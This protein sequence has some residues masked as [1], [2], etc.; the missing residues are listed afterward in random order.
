MST[1]KAPISWTSRW[2]FIMAATGSAVGLGNIWKFPYIVGDNGGGAFVLLY[3]LCIAIV[4]LPVLIAEILLG[5]NG[6]ANPI[7]AMLKAS[8]QSDVSKMWMG[9]GVMGALAG[10]LILSFYSLVG[11]WIL[12]YIMQ[13]AQSSFV[14]KTSTEVLTIFET[15]RNDTSKQLIWHG[16]F[17]SLA[18]FIVAGGV[19]KGVGVAVDIMMP[20]LAIILVVLLGYAY[21]EGNLAQAAHFLFAFDFSKLNGTAFLEALGHAMFT[22]S[23][24]M[25][26]IMVYG[27]YMPENASITRTSI[28]V[29]LLDTA[30]SIIAAL[31]IFSLV[32]ANG[33]EP[34]QGPK[35]MFVSLPLAFG[36]MSGGV[37]FA[38]LFFV[39]VS[40]AALSSAISLLE[41]AVSWLDNHTP[42]GRI[43]AAVI[44]G[45]ISWAGGIAC[46]YMDDVFDTIDFI[47]SNVLLPLGALFIA[48]FVGW[49]LKRKVAKT[50]LSDLSYLQFN[51]WYAVLR[52]FTPLGILAIFI[53][54]LWDKLPL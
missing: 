5:K 16:A 20:S 43:A 26:A 41:P 22:L 44:I 17:I 9:V 19:I 4:G 13:S 25:G 37:I 11:A 45:L 12:D 14:G 34:D 7:D 3:L 33:L 21:M 40:I 24:G 39:L 8:R 54:G 30:I 29:V 32:F 42:L 51:L 35:L 27:S 6:R 52:V 10:V 53:Y 50:Q 1:K 23:V 36:H 47:A 2:T 31:V 15:L 49:K 18:I 48:I 38:C 28:I 46:I